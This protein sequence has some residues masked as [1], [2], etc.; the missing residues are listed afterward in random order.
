MW[1]WPLHNEPSSINSPT[2]AV[3]IDGKKSASPFDSIKC[4]M[5]NKLTDTPLAELPVLDRVSETKEAKLCN[6]LIL[7]I[8]TSTI[9]QEELIN[10][11]PSIH[12]EKSIATRPAQDSRSMCNLY[13]S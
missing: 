13:E 5:M 7:H 12:G 1:C 10:S 2:T 3:N 9:S 4:D 8:K 11:C 6:G